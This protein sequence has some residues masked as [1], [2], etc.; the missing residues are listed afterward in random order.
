MFVKRKGRGTFE[1]ERA[2]GQGYGGVWEGVDDVE[3]VSGRSAEQAGRIGKEERL[4]DGFAYREWSGQVDS[5]EKE[6]GSRD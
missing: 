2:M 3:G 5:R 6:R 4:Q 1:C